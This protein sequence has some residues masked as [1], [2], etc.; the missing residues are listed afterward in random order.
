M[1][2][3]DKTHTDDGF[4]TTIGVN[5]LGHFLLTNLLLDKIRACAPAR[6]INVSSRAHYRGKMDLTDL[7]YAAKPWKPS[8]AYEQSKLA[9][10]LFTRQ[11]AKMLN[12]DEVGV[13]SLHPGVVRTDLGRHIE[14]KIGIFRYLLWGALWPF[15]KN[16][17]QGAQTTIHCAVS[18]ELE[19]KTGLYF[20][21]CAP[22]EPS[23]EGQDDEMA[24]RL[25]EVSSKLVSL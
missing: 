25:W 19:G 6:I 9:N 4:E 12:R 23:T 5:H 3:P 15:T 11:L 22:M 8:T 21:D 7:S 2:I 14:K 16:P 10:V 1:W 13:Y 18:E 20:S 24:E 17:V